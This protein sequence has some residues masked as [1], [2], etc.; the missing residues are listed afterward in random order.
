MAG[1][2]RTAGRSVLDGAL[3]VLGAF[4]D[5]RP[6]LTLGDIGAATGL[7]SATA[8]RLVAEL[9]AWGALERVA[10]GRYRIGLRLWQLGSLAPVARDLRDAALPSMQDL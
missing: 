2:T 4:S 8:Y 7:P 6:E 3:A 9:V 5:D 10:R 1:G